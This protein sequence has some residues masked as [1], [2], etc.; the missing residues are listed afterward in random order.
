[1][2][3]KNKKGIQL[4]QALG[5]VLALVLIAVLVIVSVVAFEQ[6]DTTFDS[7]STAG[8]AVN[9]SVTPTTAGVN[10][11]AA[12]LRNGA[13]GTITS[14]LNASNSVIAS[15]N[16]TQ[17]GCLLRN[18]TAL[19]GSTAAPWKVSYPY[20]YSASTAASNASGTMIVQF[21]TYP[22]LIGLVGTIIFLGIVIGVLVASFM[23][24][25][26]NP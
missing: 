16:Y 13:C 15:G 5:A 12:S 26:K 7:D 25:G 23:F 8:T 19:T 4:N 21:A 22:A 2:E 9:E 20:T 17:T 14:V 3:I 1:M 6:L 10:L 18:N 24:G 11:A